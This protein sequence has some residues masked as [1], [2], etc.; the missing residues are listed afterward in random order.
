M[1]PG[2]VIRATLRWEATVGAS[3]SAPTRSGAR[4]ERI[5]TPRPRPGYA[6]RSLP[7]RSAD[8]RGAG[9]RGVGD[10]DTRGEARRGAHRVALD[11]RGR[12]AGRRRVDD[13]RR[14]LR[15]RE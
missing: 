2:S 10:A 4:V 3:L 7:P 1:G 5:G 8:P 11:P 15:A 9:R 14:R 12:R 6:T 13:G